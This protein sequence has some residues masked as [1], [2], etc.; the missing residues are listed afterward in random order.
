M[1]RHKKLAPEEDENTGLD[2]SSLIDV[3]FLLLIY[4]IVAT[5]LVQEQKLDMAMP[6][7]DTS[8]SKKPDLEP[9]MVKVDTAGAVFWGEGAAQMQLDSDPN[10]H[11]LT[12]LYEKLNSLRETAEGMGQE[13]I[14]QLYVE[15]NAKNQRMVDV[16]NA[17]AK[18]KI[19]TVGLSNVKED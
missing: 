16:L 14:V 8:S 3:C 13:P 6:G 5:S 19:K 18:A 12:T 2:I 11:D 9:A 1:A 7:N 10:N 17:L 4:F 15:G